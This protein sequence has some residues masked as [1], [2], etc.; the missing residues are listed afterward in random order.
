M[1]QTVDVWEVRERMTLLSVSLHRTMLTSHVRQSIQS[2]RRG[3]RGNRSRIEK[4]ETEVKENKEQV[5]VARKQASSTDIFPH[6]N[7]LDYGADSSRS[8]RS[9]VRCCFPFM[10]R[11][12]LFPGQ[13]IDTRDSTQVFTLCTQ[14]VRS[15][16]P[17]YQYGLK[18]AFSFLARLFRSR[19]LCL[20]RDRTVRRDLTKK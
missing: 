18:F 15:D 7:T 4:R 1:L 13:N 12:R 3:S 16:C 5:E 8:N 17:V 19:T 9:F 10:G 14:S 6:D 20:P 11:G 2:E